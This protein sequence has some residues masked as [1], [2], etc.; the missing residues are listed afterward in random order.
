MRT[1]KSMFPSRDKSI[2][3]AAAQTCLYKKGTSVNVIFLPY[4]RQRQRC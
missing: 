4:F 2:M 1:I 3:G